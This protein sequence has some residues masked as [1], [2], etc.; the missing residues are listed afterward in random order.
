MQI[1]YTGRVRGKWKHGLGITLVLTAACRTVLSIDGGDPPDERLDGSREDDASVPGAG[2]DGAGDSRVPTEASMP[3]VTA[4]KRVFVSATAQPGALGGIAGADALCAAEAAENG[5][6]GIFIAYLH[7]GDGDLGHPAHRLAEDAGWARVDGVSA[8]ARNPH[9]V[10]PSVPLD[11]TANASRLDAGER[12]WTGITAA[13]SAQCGTGNNDA[14][15]TTSPALGGAGW[16]DPSVADAGTW[17][18]HA[19]LASCSERLHI[20]CF[21][22]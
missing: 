7:R 17:A 2:V 19:S 12:V 8:F 18:A 10:A 13:P 15:T 6:A 14:W 22:K 20:Y 5:L 1:Q 9:D 11:V 16:G 4:A 3:S 21:E